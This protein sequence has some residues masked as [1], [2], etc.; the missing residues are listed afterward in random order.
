MG[1]LT[2]YWFLPFIRYGGK[3]KFF[4][5]NDKVQGSFPPL[6]FLKCLMTLVIQELSYPFVLY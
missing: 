4:F 6:F 5:W 2:A 1:N 3:N